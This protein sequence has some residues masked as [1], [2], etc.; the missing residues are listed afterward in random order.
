MKHFVYVLTD[1][2]RSNLH[3]GMSTDLL[4]TMHFYAQMPTLFFDPS[5][6]LNRLVYFEEFSSEQAAISRFKSLNAFTK[7]QKQRLVMSVN[8]N[9]IDLIPALKYEQLQAQ[10]NWLRSFSRVA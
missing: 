2:N 3:V 7:M 8:A 5:K 6:Q 9:W 10:Q 4:K 1:R